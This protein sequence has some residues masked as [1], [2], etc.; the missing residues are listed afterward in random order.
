[1]I[2]H[3]SCFEQNLSS[4]KIVPERREMGNIICPRCT[5]SCI[6]TLFRQQ[7]LGGE[8]NANLE[9]PLGPRGAHKRALK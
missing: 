9:G 3:C 8:K 7:G 1:M 4:L 2:P 6:I 5:N